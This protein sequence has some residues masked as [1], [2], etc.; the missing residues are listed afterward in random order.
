MAEGENI[1]DEM[2]LS[3]NAEGRQMHPIYIADF[4][5]CKM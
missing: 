3:S 2:C 4:S 5:G 1:W